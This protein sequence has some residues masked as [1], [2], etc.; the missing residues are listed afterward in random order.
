M[1]SG[2]STSPEGRAVEQVAV[3]EEVCALCVID[4]PQIQNVFS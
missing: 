4:V 2:A 3:T 1:F